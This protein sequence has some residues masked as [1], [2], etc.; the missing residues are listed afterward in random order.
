MVDESIGKGGEG[1]RLGADDGI[2]RVANELGV[3]HIGCR[4]DERGQDAH[5]EEALTALQEQKKQPS[6]G[7][8]S[9]VGLWF[10]V[11]FHVPCIRF[12]KV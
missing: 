7:H 11:V 2:H 12:K 3:D 8:C 4:Y 6:A 1:R 9:R 10:L 5:E